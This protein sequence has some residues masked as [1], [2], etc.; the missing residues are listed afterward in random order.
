MG[1]SEVARRSRAREVTAAT[2][3]GTSP[4]IQPGGNV[5]LGK[6][7]SSAY[8][9]ID[10]GGVVPASFARL[11][12]FATVA[13][14]ISVN[15]VVLNPGSPPPTKN[16]ACTPVVRVGVATTR[17]ANLRW[18]P[19]TSNAATATSSFSFEAGRNAYHAYWL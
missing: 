7:V 19:S 16:T 12:R 4:A 18:G 3:P 11:S 8:T 1:L 2:E 6:R 17:V 14:A 5:G 13:F 10:F 15:S 9:L